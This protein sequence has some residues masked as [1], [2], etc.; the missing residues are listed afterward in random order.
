M[1][2]PRLVPI[3]LDNYKPLRELV[4]ESLR[5][6]ILLGR[7]KPGERLMEVQLAEEMGVSRTPV[8][9]AIRKLELDG[10]VIMVPRKG[11]YVAGITLKD[12]ADVFEVRAA[13]EGMA[14]GLAAERITDEELDQL[15]RSLVQIRESQS[16]DNINAVVEG[17]TAFHD[18][19]YQASRNQ[20]LVQIITHLREQIQRFRMTSLSQP[21]RS[22]FA[23]DEHKK[24]VEAIS[25]R[26]VELARV[27]AR[28]HIE[29]A[30][31]SLLNAVRKEEQSND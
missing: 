31:Q 20:Q 19:I 13:L 6:A 28:E 30:E 21:G 14:A 12:I 26:D 15:E 10:F 22:K 18:I 9:E 4:F 27:L 24:I 1:E 8:R 17:D 7:L 5:E 2:Q 11:A 3:M 16:G 25:D 29:N 23:L